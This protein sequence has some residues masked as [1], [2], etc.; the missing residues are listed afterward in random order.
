MVVQPTH[1][2]CFSSFTPQQGGFFFLYR[3]IDRGRRKSQTPPPSQFTPLIGGSI[4]FFVVGAYL[5]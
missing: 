5:I 1:R 4:F 2:P 3:F